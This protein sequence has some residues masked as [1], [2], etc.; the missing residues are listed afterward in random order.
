MLGI[1][2]VFVYYIKYEG[3]Y[4]FLDFVEGLGWFMVVFFL[5]F[6]VGGMIV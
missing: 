4:M 6:I 3:V 1:M 5:V 2:Y